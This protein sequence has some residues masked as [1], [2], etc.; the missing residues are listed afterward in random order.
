ME[1]VRFDTQLLENAEITGVE[2][3]QGE[4]TG[5]EVREVPARKIQPHLRLLWRPKLT[6]GSRAYHT[7][8]TRRQQPRLEPNLGLP[9]LQSSQR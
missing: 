7:Q 8:N 3:Q 5:Y 2:Y 9:C 4:L 6:P 1:L